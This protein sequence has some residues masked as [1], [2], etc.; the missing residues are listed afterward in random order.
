VASAG[1]AT[2]A[3]GFLGGFG[4]EGRGPTSG[5]TGTFGTA[6]ST[7]TRR[8]AAPYWSRPSVVEAVAPC[9]SDCADQFLTLRHS[10]R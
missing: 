10:Q 3:L 7:V 6:N 2:R 4:E 9:L 1:V 5:A 8:E